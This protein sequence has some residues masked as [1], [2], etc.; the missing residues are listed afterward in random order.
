[1]IAVE[2]I[3]A[4]VDIVVAEWFVAEFVAE[5]VVEQILSLIVLEQTVGEVVA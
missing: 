2:Q 3:V 1:V 4:A 5:I